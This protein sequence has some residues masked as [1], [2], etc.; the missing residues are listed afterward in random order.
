MKRTILF[1]LLLM[2]MTSAF[3]QKAYVNVTGFPSAAG[4]EEISLSGAVP[5]D[6]KNYYDDRTTHIGDVL[7]ML[8][9]RGFVVEQM[10]CC[11]SGTENYTRE[12]IILSKSSHQSEIV[13]DLNSDREV[14]VADVNQLVNIILGLV[15]A[16]PGLLEQVK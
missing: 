8:A 6:M 1:S 14:N 2:A 3:A 12:I 13:G 10:S 11:N 9:E 4:Y 5:S 7:N 15:K 16:N